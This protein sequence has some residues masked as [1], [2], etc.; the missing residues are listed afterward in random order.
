MNGVAPVENPGV[1]SRKYGK[2]SFNYIVESLKYG[3]GITDN[4]LLSL[5]PVP[6]QK[7]Y[8]R[9]PLKYRRGHLKDGL[10]RLKNLADGSRHTNSR[11]RQGAGLVAGFIRTPAP[12]LPGL[13]A[14]GRAGLLAE[15]VLD[16]AG[17]ED[18]GKRLGMFDWL[19]CV[20]AAC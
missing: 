3:V 15:D 18:R 13:T 10:H 9:D 14:G 19:E 11:L 16:V 4:G 17:G 1:E 8:V 2:K 5:K 12:C 6:E 7:K 20:G